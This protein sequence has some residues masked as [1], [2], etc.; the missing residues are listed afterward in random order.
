MGILKIDQKW[1]G[2]R[3]IEKRQITPKITPN[4]LNE[5]KSH[6]P[7]ELYENNWRRFFTKNYW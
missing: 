4:T 5:T 3:R 1:K 2:V 6:V 7:K